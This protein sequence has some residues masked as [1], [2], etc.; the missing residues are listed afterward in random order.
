MCSAASFDS[1]GKSSVN[2]FLTLP[3]GAIPVTRYAFIESPTSMIGLN[4]PSRQNMRFHAR[5]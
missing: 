2:S 4:F 3:N 5:D 1:A